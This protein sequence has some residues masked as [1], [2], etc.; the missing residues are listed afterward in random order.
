MMSRW[1]VL[2]VNEPVCCGPPATKSM[3]YA[4]AHGSKT[5]SKGV[6]ISQFD[7]ADR[8]FVACSIWQRDKA[9]LVLIADNIV[10]FW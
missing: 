8:R 1:R 9:S 6:D 2:F 10:G 5:T 4:R 3:A 7:N